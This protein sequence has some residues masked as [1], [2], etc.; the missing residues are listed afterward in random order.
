MEAFSLELDCRL[1]M[2][3]KSPASVV[4]RIFVIVGVAQLT[5]SFLKVLYSQKPPYSEQASLC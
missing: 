2:S 4:F 5:I 1:Y 3:C